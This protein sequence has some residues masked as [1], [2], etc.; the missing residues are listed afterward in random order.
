MKREW[1]E[2]QV[3]L[4][5]YP[6]DGNHK[7][8]KVNFKPYIPDPHRFEIQGYPIVSRWRCA[9]SIAKLKINSLGLIL[10]SGQQ[11]V[12]KEPGYALTNP[13]NHI[14]AFFISP[15][16]LCWLN[17][18]YS[19]RQ[20][21]ENKGKTLL[22]SLITRLS[23]G[24][25][26]F[27][28]ANYS[29]QGSVYDGDLDILTENFDFKLMSNIALMFMTRLLSCSSA[30]SHASVWSSHF[31]SYIERWIWRGSCICIAAGVPFIGG[32]W[33][34]VKV[35]KKGLDRLEGLWHHRVDT[36]LKPL[37]MSIFYFLLGLAIISYILA[38]LF[39]PVEAFISMRSLPVGAFEA[40]DW[41]EYWPHF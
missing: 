38:R 29:V 4:E 5:P 30:A 22:D 3:L 19:Y 8:F 28:P 6:A 9:R 12:L 2:G 24:V 35:F 13:R 25:K 14:L 16:E 40:V 17:M 27:D 36:L 10:L 20:K 1:K 41:V 15:D 18:E 32:L 23:R 7:E 31:P 21:N 33:D 26:M 37:F 11:L 34:W 39:I